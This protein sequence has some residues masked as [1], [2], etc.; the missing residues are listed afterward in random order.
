[1]LHP[2]FIE[3]FVRKALKEDLGHGHDITSE[4]LVSGGEMATAALTSRTGGILAGL[5]PALTAFTLTDPDFEISVHCEDGDIIM[6]D[7]VIAEITGPA[8]AILTAERTSLNIMS[9]LSGIASMTAAFVH[10]VKNT[11]AKIT[12]T[13]KT[14]PGL[15]LFQKY[16]V[17]MG[18]GSNH[19]FGIDDAIMIK[20]NHIAIAG[21]IKDALTTMKQY[22][23]HTLKIEIEVDDLSQL[24][25]VL[26]HG[27]ADIVLL[28]NMDTKTLQK[29]VK[30]VNNSLITEASGNMS[31]DRVKEVAQTGVDYISIGALTHS[32]PSLDIGLDIKD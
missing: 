16:A 13:R 22:A 31:L 17:N 19:R 18:G 1:M 24:E 11:N 12:C 29:A 28:D 26:S 6:T 27:G 15:R 4:L 21:S 8:R 32:A 10:E 20:D 7:T 14:L 23:G 3:D 5:I 25:E 30:M 9:H 2:I